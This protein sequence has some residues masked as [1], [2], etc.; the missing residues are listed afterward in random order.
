MTYKCKWF[1]IEELVPEVVYNQ[2]G[3]EIYLWWMFDS[4]AL[5]VLDMLREKYGKML[6]N[7][8]LWGGK[9]RMAGFRPWGSSIGSTFSQHHFGRAFDAL[10]Q[11]ADPDDIRKDIQ[12]QE[13]WWMEEI[14][15]LELNVSWLHFDTRNNLSE[16]ITF[17]QT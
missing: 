16:L 14:T 5:F 10:P 3:K 11:E 2:A 7:D 9:R 6:V 13:F 15:G 12:N 8:W 17:S 4:Q 1:Q